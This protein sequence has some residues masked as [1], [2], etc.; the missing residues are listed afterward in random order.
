ML[1]YEPRHIINSSF[2]NTLFKPF[3]P[4]TLRSAYNFPS[5]A[6]GEGQTIAIIT[7]YGNPNL[8]ANVK[9]YN[10]RFNLPDLDIEIVFPQGTPPYTSNIWAL[11]TTLDVELVHALA[12]KARILLVIAKTS[13][14]KDLHNA[15]SFAI[16]KKC[17]IISMGW[18]S[19][20]SEEQLEVDDLFNVPG[21]A[22][23]ASAGDFITMSYHG[24]MYPSSSPYVLAVGGTSL[25]LNNRGYRFQEEMCWTNSNGGISKYEP[26]PY[27]QSM[28]SYGVPYTDNRTVP[29]V[30]FLGD[31]FPGVSVYADIPNSPS[32]GWVNVGGTSVGASC[33]AAIFASLPSSN[34]KFY[35]YH[36]KLYSLA[37]G[38]CYTNPYHAFNDIIKG[39]NGFFPATKGYDCITGLGS[40]NVKNILENYL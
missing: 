23:I 26:R 25:I 39:N 37:G 21:V 20:E 38:D 6:T 29:D 33:W 31:T 8:L 30:A 15:I 35:D 28:R 11:E 16:D 14:P 2:Q 22:F 32:S 10:Q 12:P 17:T 13:D 5:W 4:N 27:W 7:A 36:S 40:P 1:T 3:T 34:N 9:V 19:A 18:G 24:A